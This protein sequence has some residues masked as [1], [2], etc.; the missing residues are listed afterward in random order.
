VGAIVDRFGIALDD[1]TTSGPAPSRP[2]QAHQTEAPDDTR[3]A[4]SAPVFV[5]RDLA[6]EIGVESPG[7]IRSARSGA[8]IHD[9]D[10]IGE[11]TLSREQA[12]A[13]LVM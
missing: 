4:A 9:S 8:E 10:L 1:E 3:K 5:I 6:T 13:L 11:G 7:A 2:L 12:S